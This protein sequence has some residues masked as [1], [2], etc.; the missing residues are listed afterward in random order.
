MG[1]SQFSIDELLR[2]DDKKS[3]YESDSKSVSVDEA[4]PD[5]DDHDENI[6]ISNDINDVC[7]KDEKLSPG[8]PVEND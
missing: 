8:S 1:S 3:K 6:D 7:I 5:N 2:H 4:E